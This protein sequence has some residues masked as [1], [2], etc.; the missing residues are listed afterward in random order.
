MRD[1]SLVFIVKESALASVIGSISPYPVAWSASQ[2]A[3]AWTIPFAMA[4]LNHALNEP[5]IFLRLIRVFLDLWFVTLL[6]HFTSPVA[7]RSLNQ[8]K[9]SRGQW[10]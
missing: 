3:V 8:Q 7:G 4:V 2:N 6:A 1:G 9:R 5:L 10:M